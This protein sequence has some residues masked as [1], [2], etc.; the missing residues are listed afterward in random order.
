MR[1]LF[2]DLVLRPCGRFRDKESF[3]GHPVISE[4][5]I[6]VIQNF[7]IAVKLYRFAAIRK[8]LKNL[9]FF[10]ELERSHF[11]QR[12]TLHKFLKETELYSNASIGSPLFI[13]R[14]NTQ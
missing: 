1:Q 2:A 9:I 8:D 7:A 13:C 14:K 3:Y 6:D 10:K 12:V 5:S 11:V 4:Q